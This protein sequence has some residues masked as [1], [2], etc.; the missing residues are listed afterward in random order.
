MTTQKILSDNID[1]IKLIQTNKKKLISKINANLLFPTC[2]EN[3]IDCTAS[4]APSINKEPTQKRPSEILKTLEK[5]K[6]NKETLTVSLFKVQLKEQNANESSSS[7]NDNEQT[8]EQTSVVGQHGEKEE[9]L[10]EPIEYEELEED[11]LYLEEDSNDQPDDAPNENEHF[12][13]DAEEQCK[14]SSEYNIKSKTDQDEAETSVGFKSGSK[15]SKVIIVEMKHPAQFVC[16]SCKAKFPNFELLKQH[17]TICRSCKNIN[18]TCDT[19]GKL[20]NSKK[21]L[22]Q[23]ILTHKEK[24]ASFVCEECGKIYSN[25][26][27]LE[28]HKYSMHHID[29]PLEDFGSIYKCKQCDAQ[30][31]NRQDLYNHINNHAKVVSN[32]SSYKLYIYKN[33]H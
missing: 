24:N 14:E 27:N 10:V 21:A 6:R 23:H 28:N 30:F 32:E 17:L 33:V 20:W 4:V 9:K 26:F 2:K 11:M 16:T 8:I 22:Y 25:R 15:K 13:Y 1:N 5:L 29:L 19:C 7:Q 3:K 12:S 31:S 18:L